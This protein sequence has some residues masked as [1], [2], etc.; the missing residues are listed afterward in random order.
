MQ[1]Q[2]SVLNLKLLQFTYSFLF[3]LPVSGV[4]VA[5]IKGPSGS[6]EAN[7][8]TP[9]PHRT[10][11]CFIPFEIGEHSIKFTWNRMPLPGAP[12]VGLATVA[13]SS[14]DTNHSTTKSRASS[15]S[16]S[17]SGGDH[18]VILTGKGLAKALIGV[19]AD[20]TIDGSRA[21]PGKTSFFIFYTYFSSLYLFFKGFLKYR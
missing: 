19:E 9:I 15:I 16:S 14:E 6:I 7:M 8:E 20:F 4:L 21:G 18:K 3:C 17:G 2:V 5:E 1:D 10:R 13:F 12:T 11:V